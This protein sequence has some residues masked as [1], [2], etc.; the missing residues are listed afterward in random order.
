[1]PERLISAISRVE[2]IALITQKYQISAVAEEQAAKT[3]SALGWFHEE[4][5]QPEHKP[6]FKQDWTVDLYLVSE[7]CLN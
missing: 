7:K 5:D 3:A 2:G 4:A 1:M 6:Q